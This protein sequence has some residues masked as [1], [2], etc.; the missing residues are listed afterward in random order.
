MKQMYSLIRRPGWT[1][2]LIGLSLILAPCSPSQAAVTAPPAAPAAGASSPGATQN[3]VGAEIIQVLNDPKLGQVLATSDGKTLYAN[4]VDS[5]DQLRCTASACTG[6]W[7]PYTVKAG[8]TTSSELSGTLGTIIRPDGS[9]QLTYNGQPLYTFYLDKGP[10]DAKG[11][12]FTDLGG[13]WHVVTP[14]SAPQS[15]VPQTN[16]GNGGYQY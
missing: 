7:P 14:G 12:G 5:P 6:F 9:T 1:G 13:T 10:G 8:P 16:N 4:T 3:A 15:A 2:L 11:N